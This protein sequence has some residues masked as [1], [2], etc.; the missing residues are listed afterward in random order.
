MFS[1]VQPIGFDIVSLRDGWLEGH[2]LYVRPEHRGGVWP[3]YVKAVTQ[4]CRDEDL[5]GFHFCSTLPMWR[6]KALAAG[7]QVGWTLTQ[8]DGTEVVEYYR[9][10]L[11]PVTVE[12][13]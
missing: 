13:A 12:D 1:S 10:V 8:M 6:T 7:F 4:L 3:A 5:R 11:P 9:A 2:L